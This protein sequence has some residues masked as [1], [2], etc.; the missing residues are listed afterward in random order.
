MQVDERE[1]LAVALENMALAD[2]PQ[3]FDGRFLL[4]N[5]RVDGGQA[6]VCFARA[7]SGGFEQLAIKFFLKRS[8]FEA[9]TQ[10]YADARLQGTLPTAIKA[11]ANEDG[12]LRSGSGYVFP[13]CLVLARGATLQVRGSQTRQH[14]M[15]GV[16]QLGYAWAA[17][18]AACALQI[19]RRCGI[20]AAHRRAVLRSSEHGPS[21]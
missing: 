5:E 1:R 2:P 11:C 3:L 4:H 10:L 8:E 7:T 17:G 9:E 14:A 6:L 21:S 19:Q 20:V 12:A 13:P 18:R 15:R 16:P